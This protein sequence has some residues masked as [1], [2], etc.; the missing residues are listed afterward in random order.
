MGSP[1][2]RIPRGF[3]TSS[4]A[5]TNAA[6]K[7]S[8]TSLSNQTTSSATSQVGI[9]LAKSSVVQG[10]KQDEHASKKNTNDSA[11]MLPE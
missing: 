11:W 4:P 7:D 6:F 5:C 1:P 2:S 8:D 3:I 10:T 9:E